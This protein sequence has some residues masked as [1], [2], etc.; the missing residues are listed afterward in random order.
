MDISL[1]LIAEY[2]NVT[3]TGKLNLMGIFDHL[4][5]ASFPLTRRGVW[6]ALTLDILFNGNRHI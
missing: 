2:A 4:G 5:A 1:A 3:N 6:L